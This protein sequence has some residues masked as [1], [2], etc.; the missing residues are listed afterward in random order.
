MSQRVPF[1]GFVGSA[2][3][4]QS[5]RFDTQDLWNW[6]LERAHSPH[7]KAG[8]ALL[9]CPGFTPF[10]TLPT[11]PVRGLFAQ[12]DKAFAVAGNKL[13]QLN[14]HGPD[15]V[16]RPLTVI[17]NPLAPVITT[18]PLTSAIGAPTIPVVTHGGAV[19]T[20]PYGYTITAM[21]AFGE[22]TG[23]PEGTSAFGN[24][25]LSSTNWNIIS[26]PA[27]QGCSGY[28]VYRT[29]GTGVAPFPRLIATVASTTLVVHDVGYLGDVRSVPT[30]NTTGQTPGTTTYR[31]RVS[32]TLGL[33]ETVAS[34]EGETITG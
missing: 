1:P 26:W 15:Y 17:A 3:S 19:G 9:P 34:P 23:S 27:V 8:Q 16:E 14:A 25:L 30:S 21:N 24:A 20:T 22:T 18:S 4:A 7:A 11:G 5:K 31:Y 10:T 28:R 29:T 33:G 32:A 12:N 6:Y 13:Y 2:F